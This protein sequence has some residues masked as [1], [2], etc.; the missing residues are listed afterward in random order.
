MSAPI[1][2]LHSGSSK[3]T[4]GVGAL[5][6]ALGVAAGALG[7][8][9]LATRLDEQHLHVFETAVR[10]HLFH[11]LGLLA[12]G[13]APLPADAVRLPAALL[14]AGVVLFCGSLY[15]LAFGG[16]LWL[17]PVT[18]LGGLCLIL[19]WAWLAYSLFSRE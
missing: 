9:G 3:P 15:A 14:G 12:I 8:H 18:P 5:L 6:M 17:G 11:A 4:A 1:A 10:F 7:A 2:T 16:P 13:L 19:G